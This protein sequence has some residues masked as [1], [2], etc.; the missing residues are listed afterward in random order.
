MEELLNA[1][2]LAYIKAV[3]AKAFDLIGGEMVYFAGQH[4]PDKMAQK[5]ILDAIHKY[6]PEWD[7]SPIEI[8]VIALL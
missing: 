1:L 5:Q 2:K 7:Y 3:E 4:V 8:V 6:D